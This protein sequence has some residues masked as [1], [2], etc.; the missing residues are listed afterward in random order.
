MDNINTYLQQI[1]GN[2]QRL[3]KEQ[4]VLMGYSDYINGLQRR[5]DELSRQNDLMKRM[6]T[7]KQLDKI[8]T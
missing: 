1:E 6:L 4:K 3:Q 5:I 7:P 8:L 2:I